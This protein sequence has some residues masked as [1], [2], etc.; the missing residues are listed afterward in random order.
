VSFFPE[1]DVAWAA[2]NRHGAMQS[3][4][5][6]RIALAEVIMP[7]APQVIGEI[8]CAM[9]GMLWAFRQFAPHVYGITDHEQGTHTHGAEVWWGDSHSAGARDWLASHAPLDLLHIDGDHSAMGIALDWAAYSPLVRPGGLV[10]V[11]DV[12][13][14]RDCPAVVEFWAKLSAGQGNCRTIAE[15]P[16]GDPLGIGI[17]EVV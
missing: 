12:A 13:N 10:M 7:A 5:E 15:S 14:P 9:G 8:G 2:V 6:L 4:S 1:G 17:F 16:E 11:H 3:V